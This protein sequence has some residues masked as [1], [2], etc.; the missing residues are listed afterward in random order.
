MKILTSILISVSLVGAAASSRAETTDPIIDTTSWE[1]ISKSVAA[2]KPEDWLIVGGI[3]CEL[4]HKL[5]LDPRVPKQRELLLEQ[6]RVQFRGK[7]VS[8]V[9]DEVRMQKKAESDKLQKFAEGF[10]SEH[11]ERWKN[12]AEHLS[13]VTKGT[14]EED[15][16]K[17]LGD[18]DG[19]S[20]TDT[21]KNWIY[22]VSA[23][24]KDGQLCKDLL[25]L[26]IEGGV[27]VNFQRFTGY[28]QQIADVYKESHP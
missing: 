27:V 26:K 11:N 22:W 7:T 9:A 18:P 28:R 8:Q 24:V 13:S 20:D 14:T 17:Y 6:L 1:T 25:T 15:V 2:A 23:S 10:V 3:P 16:L 19:K 21:T 12:R 4:G 5:G